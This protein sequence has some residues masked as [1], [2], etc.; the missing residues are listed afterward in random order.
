MPPGSALRVDLRDSEAP[1]VSAVLAG[2]GA[3][4]AVGVAE[5]ARHALAAGA[6]SL[7]L[8]R[9]LVLV[10]VAYAAIGAAAGLACW[11]ARRVSAAPAAALALLLAIAA[12]GGQTRPILLASAFALGVLALRV[13]AALLA[14]FPS[15]PR[16]RFACSAALGAI[17]VVCAL[18]ARALPAYGPRW[19]LGAAV[20]A[21]GGALLAW[22]PRVRGSALLLGGAA[23]WLV[24]Q[25]SLHVQRL[26]P[27]VKPATDA[28]SVLL[29]TI[30]ALRADRV[31]VYGYGAARTPSLDALAKQGV[32]FRN[33]IAHSGQTGPS[34]ASI[35]SGRLPAAHGALASEQPLGAGVPTLAERFAEAGYVTAAFPSARETRDAGLAGRFQFADTDL[36]EHRE[37]PRAV[38]KCSALRA[39]RPWLEGA[40]T[41][42]PYRPAAATVDRAARW[43]DAHRGAPVFAW[44]HLFDPHLPYLPPRELVA[45]GAAELSGEWHALDAAE[46]RAIATNPRRVAAMRALYD[47]EV[48]YA[49][50]E[51]GR[52]IGR[53]RDAAPGG[54]LLVVVTSDHGEPMGEHGH[55][56]RRD[57]YDETLRVP[58]VIVPPDAAPELAREVTAQVRLVDI[59][60]TLLAWLGLPPLARSDGVS[61][62]PLT[63][64]ESEASPGPA[65]SFFRP[66]RTDARPP[67]TSVRTDA[68]KWIATEPGWDGADRW[69]SGDEQLFDLANDPLELADVAAA[70]PEVAS[71]LRGVLAAPGQPPA[72]PAESPSTPAPDAA[73]GP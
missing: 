9:G 63:R 28:P 43:L 49:D 37:W 26:A 34:H 69:T 24:W 44:V 50:R 61:L 59:A 53:A 3:A 12:G 40:N 72:P 21:A 51:L 47:A 30:D 6:P 23:L 57:L 42:P 14:R 56:W 32:L 35:L 46:R 1:G 55:H 8:Q 70:Q 60:P 33:A 29:V 38:W 65:I 27:P 25:G 62:L 58:L 64:G 52:L 20:A 39:L 4:V 13:G 31:G 22:M 67:A 7:D 10:C 71:L 17:A 36:R 48:A 11:A 68:F 5:W 19:A 54:R 2:A 41:W 66:A 45:G 16:A 18:A 73:A 15:L